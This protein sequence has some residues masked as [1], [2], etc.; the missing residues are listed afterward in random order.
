MP[1]HQK[2]LGNHLPKEVKSVIRTKRR[3]NGLCT[4]CGE[5][6]QGDLFN[7]VTGK[8]RSMCRLC[9]K[10]NSEKLAKYRKE[11]AAEGLCERCGKSAP[12]A[13]VKNCELCTKTLSNNAK[14]HRR[15][16]FFDKKA[17]TLKN[18][19]V[20]FAKQLAFLWKQQRGLCKL[21]GE[22]LNR[23]NSEIDHIIPKSK[24]GTNEITNL[25]WL[26]SDVN[27]AKRALSDEDFLSLCK[28][29]V[30]WAGVC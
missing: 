1:S 24:G 18:Y 23:E 28:K 17:R 22:R 20:G 25:R 19:S 29:V 11:R 3:E 7:R 5:P 12:K 21:T 16:H 9:L 30:N 15:T 13:G 14:K 2:Q 10:K 6:V 26:L 27:Q 8:K 4:H